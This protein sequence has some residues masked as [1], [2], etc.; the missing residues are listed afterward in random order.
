[1]A[2]GSGGDDEYTRMVHRPCDYRLRLGPSHYRFN[3]PWGLVGQEM[4]QDIVFD[5][6]RAVDSCAASLFR[7]AVL[8][9]AFRSR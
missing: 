3:V 6:E 5:H 1:M 9:R 8:A 2:T 4:E 7:I